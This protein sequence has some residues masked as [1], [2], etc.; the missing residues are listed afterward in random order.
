MTFSC[1]CGWRGTTTC[2][3]H[4]GEMNGYQAAYDAALKK[5]Q[6]EYAD[7]YTKN[8]ERENKRLLAE[9]EA[10]RLMN[11]NNVRM[12]GYLPH[13]IWFIGFVSGLILGLFL[14]GG[15]P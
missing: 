3:M 1:V 12:I 11:V 9:L 7:L 5:N 14:R 10:E 6:G 2:P 15:Q 8:L 4:G 13:V